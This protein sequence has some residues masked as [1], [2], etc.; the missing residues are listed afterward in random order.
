MQQ[1]L[2]PYHSDTHTHHSEVTPI[3]LWDS[4]YL[5][6]RKMNLFQNPVQPKKQ[7]LPKPLQGFKTNNWS[8]FNLLNSNMSIRAQPKILILENQLIIAADISLQLSK[9]GYNVIGFQT[10]FED[11]LRTIATNHPDIIL[12]DISFRKQANGLKAARTIAK[13][14]QIPIV[15]LSATN[16]KELLSEIIDVRPHGFIAKPFEKKDLQR[17][18]ETALN[19]IKT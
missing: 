2:S 15:F 9:I 18:I 5:N 6:F 3:L 19:R 1:H 17:G 7:E 4:P 11:T 13:H 8:D 10:G 16:D 14:Y 12:I